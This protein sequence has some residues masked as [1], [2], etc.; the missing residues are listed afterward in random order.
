MYQSIAAINPKEI[1]AIVPLFPAGKRKPEKEKG[2]DN[3]PIMP[4]IINNEFHKLVQELSSYERGMSN[5]S[6]KRCQYL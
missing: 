1:S 3:I 4:N 6:T 5:M 2:P